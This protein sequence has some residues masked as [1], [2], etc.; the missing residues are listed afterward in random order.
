MN[1]TNKVTPKAREKYQGCKLRSKTIERTLKFWNQNWPKTKS[2]TMNSKLKR[3]RLKLTYNCSRN[4]LRKRKNN[5]TKSFKW[6]RKC[7]LTVNSLTPSRK[8]KFH[9]SKTKSLNG[10][11]LSW[12][13]DFKGNSLNKTRPKDTQSLRTKD[14]PTFVI[15]SLKS[16]K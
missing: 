7:S 11:R 5:L 16:F 15:C 12:T 3:K 14:I 8:C 4:P 6:S 1:R 13:K 10:K 2:N 9:L